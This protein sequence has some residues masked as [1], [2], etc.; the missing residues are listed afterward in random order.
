MFPNRH[1][2]STADRSDF[3]PFKILFT[4]VVTSLQSRNLHCPTDPTELSSD[5][6]IYFS[7]DACLSIPNIT[8]QP[9]GETMQNLLNKVTQRIVSVTKSVTQWDLKLYNPGE[10]KVRQKLIVL[11]FAFSPNLHWNFPSI[12]STENIYSMFEIN[13]IMK[14]MM[15]N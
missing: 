4:R 7:C 8:I 6:H 10:F 11:S 14:M 3:K 12:Q 5:R 13:F 15:E 2:N 9:P 1:K